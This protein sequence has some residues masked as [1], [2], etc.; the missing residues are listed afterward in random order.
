[1]AGTNEQ[2]QKAVQEATPEEMFREELTTLF[3]FLPD[4]PPTPGATWKRAESVNEGPRGTLNG[5]VEYT[6]RGKA[7]GGEQITLTRNLSHTPP[8]TPAPLFKLS[9]VK[10]EPGTGTI[11]FDPATGRLARQELTLRMQGTV[12][13]T[14]STRRTTTFGFQQE[15]KRTLRLLD[16]NPLE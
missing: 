1:M 4:K 15:T 16:R 13:V 11:L 9:D 3:G 6:Y 2:A 14:D 10:V 8:K 12:A 7:E 5:E